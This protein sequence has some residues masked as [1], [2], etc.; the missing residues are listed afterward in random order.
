MKPISI[1][2]QGLL[3]SMM[4][5]QH[6]GSDE[7][8]RGCL[9]GD[10]VVASVLLGKEYPAEL[11]DSKKLTEK[12]RERLFDLIIECAVDYKI[13][14][15]PPSY[16]DQHN[17]LK[18]SLYGMSQS[19]LQSNQC[20]RRLFVD[21]NHAPDIPGAEVIPVIKGDGRVPAV[22]AA[23]ILAKVTRDRDMMELHEK[24]P[25][26]AYDRHKGYPTPL[27]K[28]KLLEHGLNE[29]YRMTY[30]PVKEIMGTLEDKT[31][32]EQKSLF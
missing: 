16:I 26:M 18:A 13:V 5:V 10:V 21:G 29:T 24:Y 11:D 30:K 12:Q 20:C 6:Y 7:C 27:H 23:S 9:N 4:K 1:A 14:R 32:P 15:V 19:Y 8:G 22:S 31:A 25:D 3:E 17:I 28:Q 2:E